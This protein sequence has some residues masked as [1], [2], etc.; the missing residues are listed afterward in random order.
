M[1][2]GGPL[3]RGGRAGLTVTAVNP[4]AQTIT[5]ST[6]GRQA[7]TIT[8]SAT[9][10]FTEA[11][12][13]ATLGDVTVGEH[14]A[15]RGTR[16]GTAT[17]AATAVEIILPRE[18]GVVT[19]ENTATTPSTLTM[20]DF[21]GAT[22]TV[23]L[24]GN[25]HYQEAGKAVTVSD[26]TVASAVTVAGTRNS[27]GSLTAVHVVI[28]L[29]RVGG[30]V[31]GISNGQYTI[32][33]RDGTTKTV[34]TTSNTSYVGPRGASVAAASIVRGSLMMAEGML[35]AD[36][37]T[38]TAQRI[39]VIPAPQGLLG[40]MGGPGFGRHNDGY[41]MMGGTGLGLGGPLGPAPSQTTT[42]SA[43]TGGV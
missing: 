31:T 35:S 4:S 11:Q 38:L 39:M 28:R 37:Q 20:T 12:T 5:A 10:A 43:P 18:S 14:I 25:T 26:V 9:T 40:L 17:F 23:H 27:D 19:A 1:G 32:S 13:A 34:V 24:T 33:S 2:G 36:G 22:A 42:P 41:G 21:N 8:V 3:L 29:P 6:R 15:V 16:T 7:V 30:Q